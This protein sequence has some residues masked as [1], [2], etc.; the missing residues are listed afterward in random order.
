MDSTL[1]LQLRPGDAPLSDCPL[2]NLPR[3]PQIQA[4]HLLQADLRCYGKGDFLHM[5]GQPLRAFGYLLCGSVQ[6]TMNDL[7]GEQMLFAS[8]GPG[9]TFGESL[10]YLQVP[11]TAVQITAVAA[12]RVLWLRPD[13]FRMTS[14]DS[15]DDLLCRQLFHRFVSMLATRALSMNDRIQV[16]SK[17]TLREKLLTFFAQ[18]EHRCGSK[19]F[20]IP[21][22]R[23]SLA[24]YLGTNRS[25]LSRVLSGMRQEGLIDFYRNSFKILR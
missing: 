4:L 9:D 17:S 22:D 1:F 18:Y 15:P 5:A 10:S 3:E 13:C 19:T 21:F 16:L 20:C 12:S 2:L 25:A 24:A 23:Q 14:P 7:D 8:V 11:E 6:V